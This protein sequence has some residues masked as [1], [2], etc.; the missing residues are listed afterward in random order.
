M[1]SFII[2][3]SASLLLAGCNSEGSGT[4]SSEGDAA[5]VHINGDDGREAV[6]VG[7]G[8]DMSVDMPQGY[9]IYPGAKVITQSTVD[10]GDK[11]A[12]VIVMTSK[13][14]PEKLA[15]FYRNQAEAAG[16]AFT[17][18]IANGGTQVLMGEAPDGG[19]FS[20]SAGA[21]D[22]GTSAQLSVS[23]AKGA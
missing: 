6:N 5:Q 12:V 7:I 8:A 22:S 11:N 4:S 10:Q 9:S 15:T 1:R 13:D 20:L 17:T 3:A 19:S 16:V 14:S 18:V 23:V 2:A 21:D